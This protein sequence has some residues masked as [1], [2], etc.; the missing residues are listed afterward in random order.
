[1]TLFNS[2]KTYVYVLDMYKQPPDGSS[3]YGG[4]ISQPWVQVLVLFGGPGIFIAGCALIAWAIRLL[5]LYD[6]TKRKRWGHCTKESV[7]FRALVWSYAAIQ[8]GAWFAVPFFG[9]QA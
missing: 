5:V 3:F 8:A 4:S 9:L 2:F 7:I 1:M 6:P